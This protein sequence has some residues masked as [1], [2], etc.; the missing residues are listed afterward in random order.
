MQAD[1]NLDQDQ[2]LTDTQRQELLNLRQINENLF[3]VDETNLGNCNLVKHRIDLHTNTPFKQRHRLI[4]PNMIEKVRHHIEQL[5][6][7]GVIRSPISPW[8]HRCSCPLE[9]WQAATLVGIPDAQL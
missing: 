3:S 5:L 6:S 2:I 8:T 4:P 1:L 9:K 7:C